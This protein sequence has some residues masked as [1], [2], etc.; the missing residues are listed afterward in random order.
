[1]SIV[2]AIFRRTHSP[3]QLAWSEG[4]STTRRSACIHQMNRV[5][6][7]DDFGHDDSNINIAVVVIIISVKKLN[8]LKHHVRTTVAGSHN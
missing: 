5:N 3:S 7:R 2:A 4:L 6:F 1:M 8:S